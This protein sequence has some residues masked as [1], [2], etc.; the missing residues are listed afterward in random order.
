[1]IEG[2]G[3]NMHT[4]RMG[5]SGFAEWYPFGVGAAYQKQDE[6]CQFRFVIEEKSP[7]DIQLLV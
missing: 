5:T 4:N 6:T 3:I 2:L 7:V 1:M